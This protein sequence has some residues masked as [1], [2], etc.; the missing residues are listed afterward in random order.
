MRR[1]FTILL[2]ALMS[3]GALAQSGY[4]FDMDALVASDG[5]YLPQNKPNP[6]TDVTEIRYAL[7]DDVA[8]ADIFVYD[9]QGQQIRR[10]PLKERGEASVKIAGSELT[11][12]MYIYTLIADGQEVASKRMILTK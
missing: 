7:P 3:L 11:A 2:L 10:I 12:G 9:M 8:T 4:F 5:L 6:F 1:F